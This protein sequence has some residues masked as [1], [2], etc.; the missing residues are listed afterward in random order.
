MSD[1]YFGFSKIEIITMIA[2]ILLSIG[3]FAPLISATF[4]ASTISISLLSRGFSVTAIAI[5]ALALLS[6]Y[7]AWK[8]WSRG[9]YVTGSAILILLLIIILRL[10]FG[11]ASILETTGNNQISAIVL[12]LFHPD[13]GWLFLLGGVFLMFL[14]PRIVKSDIKKT[15]EENNIEIEGCIGITIIS[16]IIL[17][18]ILIFMFLV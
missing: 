10:Q 4:L 12:S 7:V 1:D 13:Y 9:L 5:I 16:G 6:L 15:D 11:I 2:A 3:M 18:F 8:K 14:T 17:G